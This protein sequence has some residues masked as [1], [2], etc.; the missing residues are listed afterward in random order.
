M[1][2]LHIAISQLK[3]VLA[4]RNRIADALG[5]ARSWFFMEVRALLHQV[6]TADEQAL[7]PLVDRLMAGGFASPAAEIFHEIDRHSRSS[8]VRETTRS[9]EFKW[10]SDTFP[11][12]SEEPDSMKTED[13]L[14]ASKQL[15][16]GLDLLGVDTPV[17]DA[18]LACRSFHF[19]LEGA[20]IRGRQ[21]Q[22]GSDVDLVFNYDLPQ[23]TVIATLRGVRL[24]TV[25][26]EE[27]DLGISVIPAG[28]ILRDG[29][30]HKVA[31][32]RNGKIEQPVRFQLKA[33]DQRPEESGVHVIFDRKG[34]VLYEFDLPLQIVTLLPATGV[35]DKLSPLDLDLDDLLAAREYQ[36]RT[37]TLMLVSQ[38]DQFTAYFNNHETGETLAKP[39]LTLTRIALADYLG[40]T[41]NSLAPVSNRPLWSILGDPFS[42]S[43][44]PANKD[45]SLQECLECVV[46]AGS[47]LFSDLSADE[48][49][50]D[51]L[52]LI[53]NLQPGSRLSIKTDY[54][55]LPWEILYPRPYDRTFTT[56]VKER[57][58]IQVQELWGYRFSLE[59][60]LTKG[61]T[62]KPPISAHKGQKTFVSYNVNP[63]IDDAFARNDFKPV[64][65]QLRWVQQ[66]EDHIRIELR[67]DGN[68]IKTMLQTA[69][70]GAT[71]IYLYCHG[72]NDHP[73][74]NKQ[75]EK[76]ELDKGIS[77]TPAFLNDGITFSHGPIVFLNSCSSGAFS[78]LS[79]RTFLSRFRDKLAV[80]VIATSFPVPA[81]FAA[82]F[83]REIIQTYSTGGIPI[84]EVLLNLR[85]R[86]L[87]QKNPLGLFYSLQCPMDVAALPL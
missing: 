4:A 76:L 61:S 13:L 51:V 68:A 60:L 33:A 43:S 64:E 15:L 5:D 29:V 16:E 50:G 38:G 30:W 46:E 9:V 87:N 25:L 82:A 78:P 12:R 74:T 48:V 55:F 73:F 1:T 54:A 69:N 35:T 10:E 19:L 17:A 34:A 3:G 86:L 24:Q 59:C 57:N 11:I 47:A 77:I 31:K 23:L 63:T 21:V 81:T 75:V 66:Q 41:Q 65:A 84:G 7:C 42:P 8:K 70:Y 85:R 39:L 44:S 2:D 67:K 6:T 49:F 22:C 28:F 53:D 56:E 83:G 80:G 71:L 52:E 26:N 20:A 37:A 18:S 14:Q 40:K 27:T 58:P 32:F 36:P 72:Q 79:F 62:Y 45:N